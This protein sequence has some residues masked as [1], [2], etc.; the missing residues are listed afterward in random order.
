MKHKDLAPYSEYVKARGMRWPVVEKDGQWV[1]TKFRFTEGFDP[2][3][4]VGKGIQFYHSSTN[5]DRAQIWFHPWEPPAEVPCDEYPLMLTTGRVLEHWHTGT[6]TRRVPQLSR[7]MPAAYIELNDQD[8]R[9]A[10][11]ING[12]LVEVESRR[13]AIRLQAWV[14]GRGYPPKGTAFIPFFDETLMVNEL[15]LDAHDPFSKEPDY[16]KSGVRIKRVT[17]N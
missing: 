11:I 12:D 2:Y 8:A 9:D 10:N 6:M 4:S 13:G 17:G 3:V 1:E 16:K 14:S 7:A 15:T 5:D